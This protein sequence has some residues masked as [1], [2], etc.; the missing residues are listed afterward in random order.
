MRYLRQSFLIL[1]FLGF[2]GLAACVGKPPA[3]REVAAEELS[4][5]LFQCSAD[6]QFVAQIGPK[7]AWLF[8]PGETLNLPRVVTESGEGFSAEGWKF[9]RTGETATL[10]GVNL[11]TS[12]CRNNRRL[13]IWEA[14]KLAGAD[15]RAVGNEPGWVLEIYQGNRLKISYDYGDQQLDL[16]AD[17]PHENQQQRESSYRSKTAEGPLTLKIVGQNCADSMADESY[18][19]TVY[20]SLGE[21]QFRGCGRALH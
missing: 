10:E 2:C 13:A 17:G 12:G 18:P 3:V 20:W 19:V 21:R 5:Y 7:S 14:A 6:F 1:A 11:R 4:T 8:L 15:F 9:F 16:V